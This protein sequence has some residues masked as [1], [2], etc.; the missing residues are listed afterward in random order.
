ME[1]ESMDWMP[2]EYRRAVSLIGSVSDTGGKRMRLLVTNISYGGCQAVTDR[3]LARG[4]T[5]HIS[6]PN[7]GTIAGQVRWFSGGKCGIR[8]LV[9]ISSKDERRARLG[10]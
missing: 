4:E 2:R 8:F 7:M 6:L 10:V 9:G 5:L 3:N 1:R